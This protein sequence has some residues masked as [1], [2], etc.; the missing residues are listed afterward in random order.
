VRAER[1]EQLLALASALDRLSPD[2]RTAVELRHLRGGSLEEVARQM[3][4]SKPAV[5][6][7][8]LRGMQRLRELLNESTP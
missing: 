3:D 1:N 7:L 6:K 5:A 4:R 2:Q 8:L